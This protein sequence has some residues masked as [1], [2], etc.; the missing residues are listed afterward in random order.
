M[1]VTSATDVIRLI[2]L[3]LVQSSGVIEDKTTPDS[4]VVFIQLGHTRM[5]S[6]NI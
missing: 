1:A 2:S 3:V 6:N 4:H 5:R